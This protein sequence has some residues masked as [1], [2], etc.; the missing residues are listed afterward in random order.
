M[1]VIVP[2]SRDAIRSHLARMPHR[3]AERKRPRWLRRAPARQVTQVNGVKMRAR[4]VPHVKFRHVKGSPEKA[5]HA[6]TARLVTIA[7]SVRA[8]GAKAVTAGATDRAMKAAPGVTIVL[9]II[10]VPSPAMHATDSR[11]TIRRRPIAWTI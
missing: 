9:E 11:A 8:T 2:V 3:Q 10:A 5:N 4:T 1:G 7:S 6:R